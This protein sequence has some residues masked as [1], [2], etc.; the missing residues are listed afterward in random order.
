MKHGFFRS[1]VAFLPLSVFHPCF[2]RGSKKGCRDFPP[3]RFRGYRPRQ[4]PRLFPG[5]SGAWADRV[6][7]PLGSGRQGRAPGLHR[8][9]YFR[10]VTL[11]AD[12][13][14]TNT[15]R[16]PLLLLRLSGV[17]LLRLLDVR[18]AGSLLN[19]PPRN[20]RPQSAGPATSGIDNVQ[21][22]DRATTLSRLAARG[23]LRTLPGPKFTKVAT[24]STMIRSRRSSCRAFVVSWVSFTSP[25]AVRG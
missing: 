24:R 3:E 5:F 9:D 7:C 23:P 1:P 18:L 8:A 6:R 13:P 15:T 14:A 21:S 19:D 16:H 20:T 4:P 2:I 10:A 25:A 17:L 11:G 22:L 12:P